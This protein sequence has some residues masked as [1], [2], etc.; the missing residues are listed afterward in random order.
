[1]RGS[2]RWSCFWNVNRQGIWFYL[3]LICCECNRKSGTCTISSYVKVILHVTYFTYHIFYMSNIFVSVSSGRKYVKPLSHD[4]ISVIQFN[5]SLTLK[6]VFTLFYCK[7]SIP[8]YKLPI[9]VF[10]D[11]N[12]IKWSYILVIF[13]HKFTTPPPFPIE[14]VL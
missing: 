12:L 11:L 13:Y 1:M 10:Q 5:A 14:V 2:D 3:L 7:E 4:H 8:L 6:N 9:W